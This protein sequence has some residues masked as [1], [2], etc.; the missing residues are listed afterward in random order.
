[1]AAQPAVVYADYP[2]PAVP[3]LQ[4]SISAKYPPAISAP[5]SCLPIGRR[6]T[7]PLS[8]S[9]MRTLPLTV[10]A[11]AVLSSVP[12]HAMDAK[13]YRQSVRQNENDI[14]RLSAE[15]YIKQDSPLSSWSGGAAHAANSLRLA[16]R[17][18][19][20]FCRDSPIAAAAVRT[21]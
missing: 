10:L 16:P 21:D 7:P 18:S 3:H 11:A 12:I 17:T 4:P 1:M 5:P 2:T 19:S 14:K 20:S 6:P 8:E 13:T 9:Q 15:I